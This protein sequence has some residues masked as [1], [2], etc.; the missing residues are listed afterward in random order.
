VILFAVTVPL[1]QDHNQ[2]GGQREYVPLLSD[3]QFASYQSIAD[4]L[5]ETPRQPGSS[6]VAEIQRGSPAQTAEVSQ[7]TDSDQSKSASSQ[8][9]GTTSEESHEPPSLTDG[10][11]DDTSG[12]TPSSTSVPEINYNKA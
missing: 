4:Q 2:N 7:Q 12:S 6:D 9:G 3:L 11:R 5:P 8:Q 1:R 10:T